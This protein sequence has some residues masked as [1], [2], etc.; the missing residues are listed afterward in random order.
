MKPRLSD[1]WA[2]QGELKRAP[3][4]FWGFLLGAIK[5]NLDRFL[6]WR[7]SG[8]RWSLLDYT[9]LGEY[10]WPKLPSSNG[11]GGYAVMLAITIPFM[12]AGVLLTLKRLRSARLS[13]WLV[14]LFFVPVVKIIFFLLLCVIPSRER[15]EAENE[16]GGGPKS[17]LGLIIPRS[18]V[19]SA[20]TGMLL[21]NAAGMLS[22]WLGTSV[23]RNYGWSLF[24]GLPFVMGFLVVLVFGYHE[25]RS[26]KSCL[27]VSL[28]ATF[29]AGAVLLLVAIEGIICLIMAVPIAAPTALL[30]GVVAYHI[31]AADWWQGRTT[32]FFCVAVIAPALM[33][34][35]HIQPAPLSL[36]QVRTSLVVNASPEKVWSNVVT[37][38]ELPPPR[39]MIF[40]LGIAY[41]VRARI[42]GSGVGAERHC[43]FSTGPFVEPI[44]VWDRPRLL[45]FSVTKNPAPLQEWTPYEDIH[46]PHLDGF[47]ESRAGQFHLIPL[48]DGRTQL[49][50][51]TWYYH[52]LWPATYWRWWSDYIIHTIH[53]RV[54]QHVKRLSE[55]T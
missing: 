1:L 15:V 7:V 20:I 32:R 43:E 54:L 19:G 3:Y 41:P 17:L 45:K 33:L 16:R 5:Y 26:L 36:L 27:L 8:Q 10:L 4:L 22:I 11:V 55:E 37:F 31:Q 28:L 52:H 53:G 18:M 30:G 51:T 40:R 34:I 35:E 14:L 50:G 24:V 9:R 46:P 21:A 29:A 12:T 47:L 38:A 6:M 44:E 42:H 49:E 23:L 39:E 25:A 13:P 2:W 48:P